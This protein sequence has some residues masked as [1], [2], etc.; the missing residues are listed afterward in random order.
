MYPCMFV[1]IEYKDLYM[2]LFSQI[3]YFQWKQQI[4]VVQKVMTTKVFITCVFKGYSDWR[5]I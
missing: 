5:D 2:H 4:Q 1:T 3:F